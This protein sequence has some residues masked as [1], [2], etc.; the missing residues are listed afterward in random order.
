[1]TKKASVASKSEWTRHINRQRDSTLSRAEYCRQH[2]LDYNRFGYH[3]KAFKAKSKP[4]LQANPEAPASL[5]DFIP[6]TIATQNNVS[7]AALTC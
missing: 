3:L 6:V 5:N 4:T 7:V 1:M 2:D